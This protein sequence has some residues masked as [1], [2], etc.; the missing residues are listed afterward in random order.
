VSRRHGPFLIAPKR[1]APV[2]FPRDLL[3]RLRFLSAVETLCRSEPIAVEWLADALPGESH[4]PSTDPFLPLRDWRSTLFRGD[5]VLMD[6]FLRQLDVGLPADW[7]RDTHY[8]RNRERPDRIRCY[9]FDRPG[10]ASVRVW[11]QLATP[12]RVRA[13]A[14]QL[15]RHPP[16]G[17]STRIGELVGDFAN[18]HVLRAAA[19]VGVC[20]SHPSFGP[21]S[22]V[23]PA[24]EML[25][26]RF[27]DTAEGAWP[28]RDRAQEVW[29]ELVSCCLAEQTAIDRTELT[30]WLTDS[31]WEDGAA[32]TIAERFFADSD[33]LARRLAVAAS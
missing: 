10:D 4:M 15:L 2:P 26:T 14:V 1:S 6:Q 22:A 32:E 9:L 7:S 11:L 19:A 18:G 31:G 3:R 17:Q 30:K 16:Q 25:F 29:D 21:R 13:G 8:E 24:A 20:W 27:A 23:T 28:F 12:T 5:A 33:W